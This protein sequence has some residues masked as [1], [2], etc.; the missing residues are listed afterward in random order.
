MGITERFIE[1]FLTVYRDY[2]GKWGI[3]DI[4]AYRTQGKSIKAF[5]SL[6]INIGG[7]PRTINAYLFSTGKVMIISDVTPILRGKV[8]CSGSSTRATVDMYL[9]PEEY[10]ICLGEGINGSR[11][12]LLALTRDY[13]EERVLLY[14][15]VDQKSIDYNSLVKVLGEV[16]DTLIRLFTTR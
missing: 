10:S 7:N 8:N 15:E 2:K 3:M 1:A 12:I 6:I 9:P 4:Y 11:N 13:G 14:S 5:A 16:K